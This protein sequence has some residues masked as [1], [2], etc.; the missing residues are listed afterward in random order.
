[1][2]KDIFVGEPDGLSEARQDKFIDYFY[3]RSKKYE[4]LRDNKNKFIVTGRKGTGKTLLAK[5]YEYQEKGRNHISE[6]IDKDKVLFCQL[7]AIGNREI[8][9]MERG[10]FITYAIL[11]EIAQLIC[12]NK[13]KIKFKIGFIKYLYI[14]RRI[15]K[16]E[17]ML[18]RD[19]LANFEKTS[20]K[21]LEQ[22]SING[23]LKA[24]RSDC[25][26]GATITSSNEEIFQQSPYY[27]NMELLKDLVLKVLPYYT[28]TLI[29]DD[30][31]EYD[32]RVSENSNF[33]KFLAKFI[34]VTYKLNLEIQQYS[35]D[36][37]IILL[38]RSDLF[39]FLHNQST[40]LN[41][42]VVNSRV[43]LN[44]LNDSNTDRPEQH[45]LMDMVFNKMRKSSEELKEKTNLE[46]YQQLFPKKIKGREPLKYLLN[47]S[48]GRPRDI[49]NLLNKIIVKYPNESSFT[50]EMFMAVEQEY[51]KD[52][53]NELRNEMS[54]YYSADYIN[55]CFNILKL[56]RKSNFW[57][58]EVIQV[59]KRCHNQLP[60]I[61]DVDEVLNTLFKYG[62]LG[63]MK[64]Q[65]NNGNNDTKY[66]FGYREDGSDIINFNEK[67]TVHF[68]LRK[69][70]I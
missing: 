23:K 35:D 6:Y 70:L 1:M 15:R 17:K 18:N 12:G 58:E 34:E 56:I 3:N 68:A 49:V 30:L 40:N 16:L 31:D 43:I 41:K 9:A 22:A 37:K 51:S 7:Q 59:T 29:V 21:T 57:K 46:L 67:F 60:G 19:D 52:F 28:V 27:R 65:K 62:V 11:Q 44:W 69:A 63:N 4:E 13:D 5:Y 66:Y 64:I 39:E 54:L 24:K 14:S 2:L 32:E 10:T 33:T 26:A 20:L 42:Y 45:S 8:P 25:E 61:T 50:N 47:F 36:S 53:C 38:F 55:S 48:H